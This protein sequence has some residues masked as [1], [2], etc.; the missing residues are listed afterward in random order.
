MSRAGPILIP[1]LILVAAALLEVGGDALIRRGLRGG[2][3]AT[4]ALG[5]LVL[6]AYGLVVNLV[7]WD[8]SRLLG[9]YVAAFALIAVLAGRSWFGEAVPPSTWLGLGLIVAGGLVI[10]FG[11]K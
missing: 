6:A 3:R 10:Q 7:P 8:F 9:T 11:Q 4:V 5:A 1:A 2:G